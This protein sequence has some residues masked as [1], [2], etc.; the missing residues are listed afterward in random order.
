[1]AVGY[2]RKRS[3]NTLPPAAVTS[4]SIRGD[5]P[6]QAQRSQRTIQRSQYLKSAH[7]QRERA[8]MGS[9]IW[10]ARCRSGLLTTGGVPPLRSATIA[11][12][13]L[14]S[15]AGYAASSRTLGPPRC[16]LLNAS[17]TLPGT[18]VA[19]RPPEPQDFGAPGLLDSDLG[20]LHFIPPG[21]LL[22]RS[23]VPAH[24]AYGRGMSAM[25]R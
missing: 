17:M 23:K 3:G 7:G 19:S 5:P 11:L 9:W 10:R 22:D 25:K 15:T 16:E 12:S 13:P 6:S 21:S 2:Q 4:G 14:E 18:S 8:D 20:E 1:M 24:A